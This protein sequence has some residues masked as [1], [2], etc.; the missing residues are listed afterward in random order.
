MKQILDQCTQ[1]DNAQSKYYNLS[2]NS[3]DIQHLTR[4]AKLSLIE[5]VLLWRFLDSAKQI[6]ANYDHMIKTYKLYHKCT[7]INCQVVLSF[8]IAIHIFAFLSNDIKIT[9]VL[10]K[11]CIASVMLFYLYSIMTLLHC[12]LHLILLKVLPHFFVNKIQIMLNLKLLD[13]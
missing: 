9:T 1:P 8:L 10:R 7:T 13:M 3:N 5:S 2:D 11:V 12:S 6:S 4:Y